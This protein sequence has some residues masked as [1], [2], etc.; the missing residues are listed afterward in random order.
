TGVEH[1]K[2]KYI[3]FV[4]SDD[5][6]S[7]DMLQTLY[8]AVQEYDVEVVYSAGYYRSF[9]NGEIKKTDVETK[10]PQ[11]FEGGDVASKLLPDV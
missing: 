4:D 8:N 9:S 7:L 2:G 6:V 10:K 1:A 11:L 5:Y 3:T